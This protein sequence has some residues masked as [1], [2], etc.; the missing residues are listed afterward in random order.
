MPVLYLFFNKLFAHASLPATFSI[1]FLRPIFKKGDVR[2]PDNYRGIAVGTALSKL[3]ELIL[4]MRLEKTLP[5]CHPI[6]TNQIGFVKSHRTADHIFVIK[7]IVDKIVKHNKQKLWVA[8]IDFRKA[9]DRIN[10]DLLYLNSVPKAPKN[11][12]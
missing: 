4:L 6:S 11:W 10:R 7:S 9:Y 1:N 3:F 2:D 12:Y 8:F 5:K